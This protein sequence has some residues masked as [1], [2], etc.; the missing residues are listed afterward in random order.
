MGLLKP[1]A[2]LRISLNA[3]AL[4]RGS[5]V[6]F[7]SLRKKTYFFVKVS[8]IMLLI[9]YQIFSSL[10]GQ[11][12]FSVHFFL[13]FYGVTFFGTPNIY[14]RTIQDMFQICNIE[15]FLITHPVFQPDLDATGHGTGTGTRDAGHGI[16][17]RRNTTANQQTV[18]HY[19]SQSRFLLPQG[20][21]LW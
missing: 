4:Q 9:M 1:C 11:L 3:G 10:L 7:P 2:I 8:T 19:D 16:K 20:P 18:S 12:S 14:Q 13:H 17:P 15:W 5:T 21:T 6:Y